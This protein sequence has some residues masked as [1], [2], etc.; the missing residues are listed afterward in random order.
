MGVTS[1]NSKSISIILPD[2]G[3]GGA[4]RLYVYLASDWVNK[5]YSVE[6]VVMQKRKH[7]Y[8]NGALDLVPA[9]I[10][11]ISFEVRKIRNIIFPLSRYLANNKPDVILSAMW[12]LT[13]ATVL[14]WVMSGRHGRLYLA[15][16]SYLTGAIVEDLKVNVYWLKFLICTTY[17]MADGVIS[18]SKAAKD[19]I[20]R[21][22]GINESAIRV[23]YNPVV[24]DSSRAHIYKQNKSKIWGDTEF[25]VLSVGTL[26]PEKDF[27]TLIKAFSLL[28]TY[29]SAKLIILGE[30]EERRNL[31]MLITDL[32]LQDCVSMPGYR[33]NPYSWY[34]TADMFVLSSRY[35]GFGNV[36]VEALGCGVPVVSTDCPG[37]PAEILDNGRYGKLIPV[38][39]PD[40]MATAMEQSLLEKH[41]TFALTQRSKDF[42]VNKI[43]KEYLEYLFPEE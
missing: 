9:S 30:G 23:I 2:L 37:G 11:V 27:K 5:G 8:G 18:V 26:K 15:D 36:I 14:S 4:E 29:M 25:C 38:G 22:S 21:L 35:E 1:S 42:S 33:L 28:S 41:D 39:N 16:H 32:G 19:N 31:E 7:H 13:S 20:C 43:S 10:H 6:F 12:P 34:F 3:G 40:A 24:I 17:F